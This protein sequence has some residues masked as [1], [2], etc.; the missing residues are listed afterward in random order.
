MNSNQNHEII[1]NGK[2]QILKQTAPHLPD[3]FWD[4]YALLPCD[5][6][7]EISS[8]IKVQHPVAKLLI[9]RIINLERFRYELLNVFPINRMKYYKIKPK[10][11]NYTEDEIQFLIREEFKQY[12]LCN[13][14]FQKSGFYF[15]IKDSDNHYVDNKLDLYRKI[16]TECPC[17]RT[18]KRRYLTNHQKSQ[19]C[20]RNTQSNKIRREDGTELQEQR[21]WEI[22]LRKHYK[23]TVYYV[24]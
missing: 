12:N 21:N 4:L 15:Y 18:L 14:I 16:T 24:F 9:P 20:I 6:W 23:H 3:T 7:G 5:M 22:C 13:E 19:G 8:Y 2:M 11:D 17:G 1:Q 10:V